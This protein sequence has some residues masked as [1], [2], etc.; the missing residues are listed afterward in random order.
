M[1]PLGNIFLGRSSN[2]KPQGLGTLAIFDVSFHGGQFRTHRSCVQ[3]CALRY[4]CCFSLPLSAGML[5]QQR[6]R[7]GN[8]LSSVFF[9]EALGSSSHA[10]GLMDFSAAHVS[11]R[12][13]AAHPI[14]HIILAC[15]PFPTTAP[16]LSC[17][18][19]TSFD[20]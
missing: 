17:V 14:P 13:T 1:E 16:H 11:R 8:Q 18:G 4:G 7:N 3:R 9:R 2:C 19:I 15:P 10:P 6:Q 20:K 5:G 12:S